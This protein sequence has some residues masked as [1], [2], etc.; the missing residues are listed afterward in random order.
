MSLEEEIVT[1]LLKNSILLNWSETS[2]EIMSMTRIQLLE[3]V[4]L[5]KR[6]QN[7]VNQNKQT[8]MNFDNITKAHIARMLNNYEL[9]LYLALIYNKGL[10][11][12]DELRI[13]AAAYEKLL[14]LC[15]FSNTDPFLR[16][17]T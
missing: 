16:I 3:V 4:Q 17:A 7:W 6:R 12:L 13:F 10:P 5:F 11:T 15:D 8:I 9:K 1:D 14:W 2:E